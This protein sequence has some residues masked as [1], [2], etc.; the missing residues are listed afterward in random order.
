MAH[1]QQGLYE[2]RVIAQGFDVSK[3]KKTPCFWL[4]FVPESY[5]AR[6]L[7]ESYEREI[8]LWLT[9]GT[10]DRVVEQLR[11]LGW[12]GSDFAELEPDGGHSFEDLV[13]KVRCT[14]QQEDDKVYEN[15]EL[16][17][18]FQSCEH[19][20]GMTRKLN[21]LFGA[22]LKNGAKPKPKSIDEEVKELAGEEDCP[23]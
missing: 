4:R 9:D 21:A 16:P 6:E 20:S 13:I 19:K 1:Y 12:Q 18:S 3:E 23:F 15:W 8:R 5:D 22:K 14:H 10:I 7:T 11:N 2:C 17:S